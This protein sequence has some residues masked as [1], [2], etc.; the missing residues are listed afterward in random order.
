[1]GKKCVVCLVNKPLTDFQY[2]KKTSR[3]HSYCKTCHHKKN[4]FYNYKVTETHILK[5]LKLQKNRCCICNNDIKEKYCI[6]HNH[7]T[8]E[9]RGLLCYHCNMGLG[10]FKDRIDLLSKAIVFLYERGSYGIQNSS[11]D[12]KRR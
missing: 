6:D 11:M 2:I 10:K 5:I 12:K 4:R 9:I 8:K 1:L 7:K 3:Y